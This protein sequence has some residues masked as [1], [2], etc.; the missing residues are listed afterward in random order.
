VKRPWFKQGR[1]H[2][3]FE[4]RFFFEKRRKKLLSPAVLAGHAGMVQS[5][6]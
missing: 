3:L 1:R 6:A 2:F 5:F 4:K